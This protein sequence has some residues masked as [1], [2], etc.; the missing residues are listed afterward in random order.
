MNPIDRGCGVNDAR[1][2]NEQC[3]EATNVGLH[4]T[5]FG[6]GKKA[7]AGYIVFLSSVQ[8]DVDCQQIVF[9]RRDHQ[10]TGFLAW[11]GMAFVEFVPE[12][13]PCYAQTSF[14]RSGFSI[15][16]D[17]RVEDSRVAGRLV[18]TLSDPLISLKEEY[19]IRRLG[20]LKRYRTSDYASTDN[21]R[22][23]SFAQE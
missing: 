19:T 1:S 9:I 11:N 4:F 5:D 13:V 15:V 14:Q 3:A 17:A 23:Y 16:V 10:F 18:F 12:P 2:G 6:A 7:D 8:V 22:F 20:Q 21:C